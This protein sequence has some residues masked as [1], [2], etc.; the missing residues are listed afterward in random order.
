MKK[1][2]IITSILSL[3]FLW[4]GCSETATE[5]FEQVNKDAAKKRLKT[6]SSNQGGENLSSTFFYDSKGRLEKI[7]TGN[8]NEKST[9]QYANT[10]DLLN[11]SGE[12]V[13]ETLNVETLYQSP[14]KA[15]ELGEVLDYDA[16]KNP[17]KI[18]FKE[19]VY[20]YNTQTYK[21]ISLTAEIE[22]D[23]NPNFYFYTLEAAG[24]IDILDGVQLD[25]SMAAQSA[26]LIKA[27]QLLPL[28]NPVK[29]V[30]KDGESNVL[31]TI[32]VSYNYDEDNY[33]TKAIS[34]LTNSYGSESTAV[35]F[36]Y[37]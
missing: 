35:D 18:L 11:V 29:F 1:H 2:T 10:G 26:E 31:S 21:V 28:N 17:S 32:E 33:P 19:E 22:Y 36:S 12:G 34:V 14:Y 5:D 23:E 9:F 20:D 24:I 13:N 16:R 7:E 4:I 30:Y 37:E 25:F 27:R 8:V 6:I 15:F 3:S